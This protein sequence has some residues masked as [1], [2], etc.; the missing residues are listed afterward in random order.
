MRKKELKL[1][2]FGL[3][4]DAMLLFILI[5]A[6]A[7]EGQVY[8]SPTRM[9]REVYLDLATWLVAFKLTF[10]KGLRD[11]TRRMDNTSANVY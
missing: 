10:C 5:G 9:F 1:S 2:I 7:L 6:N 3:R 11:Y 4:N 8:D